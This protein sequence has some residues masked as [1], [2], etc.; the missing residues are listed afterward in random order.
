MREIHDHK[1]S[2]A[3]NQLQVFALDE[4]GPGGANHEYEAWVPFGVEPG[5]DEAAVVYPIGF[6]TGPVSE[7]GVNGLTNET[8]LAIVADRLRGFQS[9]PFPC[10]ENDIALA[11]IEE[12][13]MWLQKRTRDRMARGVE[14]TNE[15]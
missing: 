2:P 3:D 7:E 11:R 8:L 1:A 6:Q 5:E 13:M 12:A 4:P 14:G 15:R 9:G 10:R